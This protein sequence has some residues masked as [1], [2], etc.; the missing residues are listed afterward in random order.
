MRALITGGCGFIGSNLT[1]ACSKLG[2]KIDV[3]DWDDARLTEWVEGATHTH[4]M[5]SDYSDEA[6]L[7]RV[8]DG[9]YDVILH[10]AA[11]PRVSYSVEHPSLTTDENVGKM[12]RLLE[13]ASGNC[14]RFVFSSSSSVYGGA[15]QL[16]TPET[17]PTNPQSPYALQKLVGEQYLRMFNKLYDLDCVS[18]RYFNVFGPRQ[19]GDN[20]Y[21]TVISAWLQ[22]VRDGTPLRLD[23][24]GEQS[25]DFCTTGDT[26]VLM[27]DMTYKR[28]DEIQINDSVLSFD[29]NANCNKKRFFKCSKVLKTASYKPNKLYRISFEN[30][31]EIKCTPDHPFLTNRGFKTAEHLYNCF[32]KNGKTLELKSIISNNYSFEDYIESIDIKQYDLGYIAGS[33][34]GDGNYGQ[35]KDS[36][37]GNNIYTCGLRVT[38]IEFSDYFNK[39]CLSNGIECNVS[40]YQPSYPGSKLVN[41]VITN[42]KSSFE[43]IDHLMKNMNFENKDFC[44]GYIAAIFDGEGELGEYQIRISNSDPQILDNVKN[45]LSMFGFNFSE[46]LK[47]SNT[48]NLKYITL[49]GGLMERYRFISFFNPKIYRKCNIFDGKEV[50]TNYNKIISI[51]EINSEEVFAIEIENTHTY[52]TNGFLS[53]NCFVDNVVEANI[54]AATSDKTFSGEAFNIGCNNRISLNDILETV[55]GLRD[56][57]VNYAPPRA[58]DVDHSQADI[59]R[60]KEV[61]GYTGKVGFQ[62]GFERTLEWWGL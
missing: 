58:G 32:T 52:V 40:Y 44:K 36:R 25:R 31:S 14:R 2:W 8:R 6:I 51:D 61:L 35:Y 56:V 54:L 20:A 10:L 48:D 3:A 15:E 43:F 41:S 16:P 9:A 4:F 17:A 39:A 7:D 28:A 27:S 24:T 47:K 22:A 37:N 5:I 18:L 50:K 60:A 59:S 34:D 29:E 21:A 1:I 46:L 30:G 19:Y 55:K 11:V 38:D 33:I 45:I 13:A 26:M 62:E 23:G 53:H 57:E 42:K 49:L 12:V